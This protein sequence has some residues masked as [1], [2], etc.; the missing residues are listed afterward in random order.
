MKFKTSKPAAQLPNNAH[1]EKVQKS[2]TMLTAKYFRRFQIWERK[3]YLSHGK[4]TF[5][6]L[7]LPFSTP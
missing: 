2:Q 4:L 5:G 6:K 7:L 1:R 3:T